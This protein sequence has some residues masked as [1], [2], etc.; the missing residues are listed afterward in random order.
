MKPGLYLIV[1][2]GNPGTAYESTR[3]NAG[4]LFLDAFVRQYS[5]VNFVKNKRFCGEIC[6]L[7]LNNYRLILLKPNT[8]M[9]CSGKSVEILA[10]YY[11]IT[12]STIL[13]VHDE[14][15]LPVGIIRLKNGGSSGGHNGLKNLITRL[16]NNKFKRL[17]IGI[18]RP[19]KGTEVT[20]YVLSPFTEQ[21]RN[22]INCAISDTLNIIPTLINGYW[23]VAVQQLHTL[24]KL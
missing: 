8:Y 20:N 11:G 16:N 12:V 9:N 24:I 13:V 22:T 7:S 6:Q 4:F 17:R 5:S 19:L 18:G 1:G 3:H 10:A 23:N 14:L 2:L 15:D 21:E